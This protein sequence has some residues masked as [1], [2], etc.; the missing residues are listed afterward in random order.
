MTVGRLA[1]R[2]LHADDIA[3]WKMSARRLLLRHADDFYGPMKGVQCGCEL[4]GWLRRLIAIAD[5]LPA[6]F[7]LAE[8]AARVADI[9]FHHDK[10]DAEEW[11][12]ACGRLREALAVLD[13]GR[14]GGVSGPGASGGSE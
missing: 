11:Q 6:W 8:A 4:C 13:A 3:D 12:A 1:R 7:A 9:Q 5:A 10:Y 2:Q 14:A